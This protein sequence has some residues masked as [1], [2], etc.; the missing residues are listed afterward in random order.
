[1]GC[2]PPYKFGLVKATDRNLVDF[3]RKSSGPQAKP[4][5]ATRLLPRHGLT[6][7]DTGLGTRSVCGPDDGSACSPA[8]RTWPRASSVSKPSSGPDHKRK[9]GQPHTPSVVSSTG[10]QQHHFGTQSRSG[11]LQIPSVVSSTD[12]RQTH[13]KTSSQSGQNLVDARSTTSRI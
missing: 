11:P 13:I 5:Q 9:P 12:S 1:V 10:P 2:S 4:G 7:P 6:W 3:E 8:H